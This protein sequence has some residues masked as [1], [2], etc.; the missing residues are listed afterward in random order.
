MSVCRLRY[1]ACNAHAPY[2]RLWPAQLYNILPRNLLNGTIF[3][4]KKLM[5]HEM[6][7]LIFSTT[8]VS[9]MSHSK[10]NWA[11]YSKIYVFVSVLRHSLYLSCFNETNFSQQNFWKYSNIKF[12][13]NPLSG[14]RVVPCEWNGGRTDMSKLIVAFSILWTRLKSVVS[15]VEKYFQK[16]RGLLRCWRSAR[17]SSV[18]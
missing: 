6:R 2:C 16:Q 13:E 5:E 9:N 1:P 17:H 15:L 10:K 18:K 3:G 8:C 7:V 14:S 12:H 4:K 11:R